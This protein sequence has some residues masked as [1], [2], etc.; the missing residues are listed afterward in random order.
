M[1]TATYTTVQLL[2]PHGIK[3]R[4]VSTAPPRPATADEI[5]LIDLQPINGDAAARKDLAAK[6][7]AAAENN[8]FFYVYNHGIPED[9]IQSALAHAKDFFAQPVE[10]KEKSS[11][12][13]SGKQSSGYHGVG[14]TQI[15]S[16]ETKGA[17]N[18]YYSNE[19]HDNGSTWG[20]QEQ[21]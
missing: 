15:N 14:T 16:K 12:H 13:L 5:P 10:E 7:K 1:A 6:V 11:F 2:T 3:H 19:F 21:V 8:G 4:R 17:Y 9:L 18:P 20:F